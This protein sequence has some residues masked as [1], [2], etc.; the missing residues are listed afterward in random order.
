MDQFVGS[1]VSLRACTICL[2]DNKGTILHERDQPCE[3][4]AIAVYLTASPVS[5]TCIGFE[6]GTLSQHLFYEL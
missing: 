2:V 1:D 3:I 4:E 6:S 5:I